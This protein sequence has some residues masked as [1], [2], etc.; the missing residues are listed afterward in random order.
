MSNIL[1][2]WVYVNLYYRI[3]SYEH[4]WSLERG[5][6]MPWLRRMRD[7]QTWVA[8]REWRQAT[9]ALLRLVA[10]HQPPRW[11]P[12]QPPVG[13][14]W[15]F[16]VQP[17]LTCLS[18]CLCRC[19]WVGTVQFQS[20]YQERDATTTSR[21]KVLLPSTPRWV[22]RFFFIFRSSVHIIQRPEDALK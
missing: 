12:M 8:D 18:V 10:S 22:F 17:H 6:C 7:C 3:V 9:S 4:A 13:A 15:Q 19:G 20:F 5:S 14:D 2:F 21:Q 11:S 16:Q 1:S